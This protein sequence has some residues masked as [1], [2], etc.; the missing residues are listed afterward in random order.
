MAKTPVDWSSANGG[1]S[2]LTVANW[3]PPPHPGGELQPD[4]DI[5]TAHPV[6][7]PD[8]S[9]LNELKPEK[10]ALAGVKVRFPSVK[11]NDKGVKLKLLRFAASG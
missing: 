1:E 7:D 6:T 3:G 11:L 5:I 9:V 2:M 8:A 10:N 4:A